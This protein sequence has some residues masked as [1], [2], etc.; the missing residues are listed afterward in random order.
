[1]VQ[2]PWPRC[3]LRRSL[4]RQPERLSTVACPSGWRLRGKRRCV[5]LG[6]RPGIQPSED[7][8]VAHLSP[9]VSAG[10]QGALGPA[11]QGRTATLS[12]PGAGADSARWRRRVHA[13]GDS[14][15]RH[16]QL[17]APTTAS[18]C[19]K[20][21]CSPTSARSSCSWN[22][23]PMTPPDSTIASSIAECLC[24]CIHPG[25][26]GSGNG[27]F[28]LARHERWNRSAWRAIAAVPDEMALGSDIT[29]AIRQGALILVDDRAIQPDHAA[30]APHPLER[31]PH[32]TA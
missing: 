30:E 25:P 18:W 15:A 12:D 6:A 22:V 5:R 1:M 7:A 29:A 9:R 26:N 3:P 17:Q 31:T 28:A 27:H 24:R 10:R 32:G 2:R 23:A 19:P 20:W 14:S 8:P 16:C 13:P 11:R 21:P 4:V